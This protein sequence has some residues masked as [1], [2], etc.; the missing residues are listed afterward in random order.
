MAYVSYTE[1][2]AGERDY[3]TECGFK[4]VDIS[5]KEDPEVIG[6]YMSGKQNKKSIFGLYIDNGYAYCNTTTFDT[7]S[8]RNTLEIVDISDKTSPLMVGELELD[9]SPANVT[10]SENTAFININH[11]DYDQDQYSDNSELVLV[12]IS[13]KEKPVV[14]DSLKVPANSWGIFQQNNIICLSSHFSEDDEYEESEEYED[15]TVEEYEE[16]WTGYTED[17]YNQ[18]SYDGY[19]T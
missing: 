19:Y 6:D 8:E 1:W 14:K 17:Q 16:E 4:I 9:G 18:E 12:D 15:S 13:D 7:G 3:Y 11:Y 2:I 5:D 10:V